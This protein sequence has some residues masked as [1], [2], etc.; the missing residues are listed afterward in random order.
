M[1][2]ILGRLGYI[3]EMRKLTLCLFLISRYRLLKPVIWFGLILKI[4]MCYP[5]LLKERLI[6][7]QGTADAEI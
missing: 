7:D 3:Y 6:A 4:S 5:A 2:E 1:L